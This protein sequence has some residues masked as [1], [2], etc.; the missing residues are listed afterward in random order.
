MAKTPEE[1]LA[2]KLVK[3]Q[4]EGSVVLLSQ[5]TYSRV[6]EVCPSGIMTLDNHVIG[7]GGM[8]Y[9]R[10]ME[11][12]GLEGSGK[13]T[14]LDRF[15]AGCQKDDGIAILTDAENKFDEDWAKLHGVDAD[16]LL[17][18]Q[19]AYL[20]QWLEWTENA[21][22]DKPA[23]R[24]MLVGLDSVAALPTEREVNQG[25]AG[26]AAIA[27]AARI[28]SNAMKLLPQLVSRHRVAIILL[29]QVRYK[30]GVM[31]GNPE[32]TPGG[33]AIKAYASIRLS[34]MHG[35]QTE[36][37]LGRYMTV[38]AVKNQHAR[39]YN[40]ALL[41]LSF[42]EGFNDRWST[43]EHAKDVGCVEGKCRSWKEAM[44]ALGWKIPEDKV[45]CPDVEEET[46]VVDPVLEAVAQE[47]AA[48][49]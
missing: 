46:K 7:V 49:A 32:T 11:M 34:V 27:E 1:I 35:K 17:V 2:N 42:T 9:G 21:I 44:A 19:P 41:K 36:D 45:D 25:L 8:P 6:A 37:K 47:E 33:N 38:N 15:L 23:S 16:K 4:G 13:T 10:I 26:E 30:I 18:Q 39:P 40:K 14:L 12:F 28:W 20:E 22:K 31:Y 29:N 3:K 24:P 43:L 48:S 5:G